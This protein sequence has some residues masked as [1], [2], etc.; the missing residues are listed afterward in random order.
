MGSRKPPPPPPP[1]L[2]PPPRSGAAFLSSLHSHAGSCRRENTSTHSATRV[3]NYVPKFWNL[4]PWRGYLV[5]GSPESGS[6][7]TPLWMMYPKTACKSK[8]RA[9]HQ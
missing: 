2:P 7:L 3:E 8:R 1:S 9:A 5:P 4:K 6:L